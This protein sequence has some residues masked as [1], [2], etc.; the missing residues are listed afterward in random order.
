VSRKETRRPSEDL[1]SQLCNSCN[2]DYGLVED[3][4][5]PQRAIVSKML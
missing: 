4:Q 5:L 3:Y 1:H 2:I